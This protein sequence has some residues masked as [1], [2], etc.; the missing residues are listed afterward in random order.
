MTFKENLLFTI[1]VAVAVV[2][3]IPSGLFIYDKI[4]VADVPFGGVNPTE[5]ILVGTPPSTF[6]RLPRASVFADSTTTPT[7]S[8]TDNFANVGNASTTGGLINQLV[9]VGSF[10]N[11]TVYADLRAGTATTTVCIRPMWSYNNT[12]YYGMSA[13]A[14]T[15]SLSGTTTPAFAE[16]EICRDPGL[17]TTTWMFTGVVPA[18]KSARFIIFAEDLASDP[19]DGAEGSIVVTLEDTSGRQ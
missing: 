19:K 1:L 5:T 7:F 16:Q 14:T 4:K 8:D 2:V 11:Y 13:H 10:T 17:A 9:N 12:D 6:I 18:A 15:T 3:G